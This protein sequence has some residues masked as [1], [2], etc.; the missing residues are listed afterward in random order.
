MVFEEKDLVGI[1]K[2]AAGAILLFAGI[3]IWK[4]AFSGFLT[5][6]VSFGA[7][8]LVLSILYFLGGGAIIA[9]GS[10]LL[11]RIGSSL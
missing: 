11:Y 2:V 10:L 6:N 9:S 7:G 1:I 3:E 8:L 4:V 5:L